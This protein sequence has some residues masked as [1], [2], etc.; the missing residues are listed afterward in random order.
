MSGLISFPFYCL[1]CRN[2][3]EE[4]Y[5]LVLSLFGLWSLKYLCCFQCRTGLTC[6]LECMS[7]GQ[8]NI[9]TKQQW[10]RCPSAKK[11]EFNQQQLKWKAVM[12]MVICLGR[13]EHSYCA[14]ISFQC[15]R[16]SPAMPP[17]PDNSMVVEMPDEDLEISFSRAGGKGGQKSQHEERSQLQNKIKALSRLKAKPLVIAEEQ[18]AS[19]IKQI[20]GEVVKA[21]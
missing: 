1:N 3:Y 4:Q 13:T 21:E 11:L 8:R 19:E 7:D 9:N 16:S 5:L 20:K 2:D 12:L 15:Q 14:A 6:L 17:L 10:L 18:R